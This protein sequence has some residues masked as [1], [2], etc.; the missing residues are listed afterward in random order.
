MKDVI[1]LWHCGLSAPHIYHRMLTVIIAPNLPQSFS[2]V[3][4]HQISSTSALAPRR[5]YI[6]SCPLSGALYQI[7]ANLVSHVD[8]VCVLQDMPTEEDARS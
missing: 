8:E 4:Q 3:H 2:P 1:A 6:D 5:K 7:Q